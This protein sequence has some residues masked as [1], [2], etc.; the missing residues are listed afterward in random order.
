MV[1]II[2]EDNLAKLTFLHPHGPSNSFKYP[3]HQDTRTVPIADI[4]TLIDPRTRT[5][6]V[7]TLTR[8]ENTAPSE[9]FCIVS[10]E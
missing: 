1:E 9:M 8:K 10:I 5:G 4:L 2:Q 3:Q 6:R 7:Y